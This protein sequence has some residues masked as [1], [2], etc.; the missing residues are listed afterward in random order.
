MNCA[1][2]LGGFGGALGVVVSVIAI[3][4]TVYVCVQ[5]NKNACGDLR[6]RQFNDM[7]LRPDA[8]AKGNDWRRDLVANPS[9]VVVTSSKS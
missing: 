6:D 8:K 7:D 5:Q 2:A 9:H 3:A 4:V 1:R